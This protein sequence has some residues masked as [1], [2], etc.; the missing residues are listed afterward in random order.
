LFIPRQATAAEQAA[1]HQE[2]NSG[3]QIEVD[4]LGSVGI[5]SLRRR[6]FFTPESAATHIKPARR[7]LTGI[8]TFIGIIY[9]DAIHFNMPAKA[10]S[11]SLSLE[12]SLSE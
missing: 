10:I 6:D 7:A 11:A 4:P 12:R 1:Q 3:L 2:G 8:L 5:T 9:W